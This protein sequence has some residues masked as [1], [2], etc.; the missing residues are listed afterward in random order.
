M[1]G[2][3]DPSESSGSVP[4]AVLHV[5][6]GT[7]NTR[8]AAEW[9]ADECAAAGFRATVEPIGATPPPADDDDEPR[10]VGHSARPADLTGVLAPTHGFTAPWPAIAR[11]ARLPFGRGRPAFVLCTRGGST[12][13]RLR[14]PGIAGT[15]LH[16]LALILTLRGYAVRGIDA[17]NMPCNWLAVHPG[18]GPRTTARIT[19]P[20]ERK[21]RRFATRIAAGRWW[22][23]GWFSLA[24]GIPLAI[25][26]AMYLL[27]GRFLLAK[28]FFASERCNGCG[29][30]VTRCPHDGVRMHGKRP[31]WRLTCESCMRCMAYCPTR[32]VEAHQ[33][34][35]V[36]LAMAASL[37]LLLWLAP[38]LA[39]PAPPTDA[40]AQVHARILSVLI[41]YAYFF[42]GLITAYALFWWAMRV[43]A[44]RAVLARLTLT[45]WFRRSH[46]PGVTTAAMMRRFVVEPRRAELS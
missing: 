21:V 45:R 16:L 3:A 33:L 18:I 46:A 44:I 28:L 9:A 30:C 26:S 19:A 12:I 15:A 23:S 13:G 24:A 1:A 22:L 31:Y 36:P 35:A 11:A 20:A 40:T 2:V 10:R 43:S 34:W 5:M 8:R 37:P 14:I 27:R 38:G 4:A 29:L 17:V 39:L 42:V 41:D 6:S 25:I 32:A 7:G